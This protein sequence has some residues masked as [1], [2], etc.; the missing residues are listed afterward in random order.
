MPSLIAPTVAAALLAHAFVGCCWHHAQGECGEA[1]AAHGVI[2]HDSERDADHGAG[3]DSSD[4]H[5]E[6]GQD[7]DHG[8]CSFVASGARYELQTPH[9]GLWQPLM[10]VEAV[11]AVAAQLEGAPGSPFAVKGPP[12]VARHLLH[13][14]LVV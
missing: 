6:H 12:H 5:T 2:E 1:V 10:L 7:C 8:R 4:G 11:T 3:R 13:Q 9:D 14:V